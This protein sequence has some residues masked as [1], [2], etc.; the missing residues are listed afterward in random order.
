MIRITVSCSETVIEAANHYAMCI[1]EGPN[2][3]Y[4]YQGLN[5]Q[6]EEGNLYAATSFMV[7]PEWVAFAQYPVQHP[8]WDT[9]GIVNMDLARLAQSA[10]VFWSPDSETSAPLAQAGKLTA[11]ANSG[12]Q[13][14]LEAMGL[15]PVVEQR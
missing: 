12:V 15:T 3:Q 8:E 10:L 7:R 6:D 5:W 13:E 11:Y 4:T 14:A 2:D 1:G 9:D